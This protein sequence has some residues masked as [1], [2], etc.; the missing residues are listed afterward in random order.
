[1][2]R[3]DSIRSLIAA[4]GAALAPGAAR[5]QAGFPNRPIR[6][7]VP[8]SPGGGVDTFAR[9][10]AAKVKTQRDVHFFV[11]NRTGGNSTIGGLD[12]QHA[13][14]DGST[15]LFHASTH[16]VA[17]L[18]MRNV[19]YDP[20][21]D[22]TPIA[23]AGNA[24]LLHIVAN[25]RQEKTVAEI[26]AAAKANR[27]TWS[28][29]TAQLGAPGHL[30]AV[31]FNQYTG[32][33]LPIIVYRGTAPAANDVVGGHVP[34]MIEAILA[35]LPLVRTGSVRAVGLT[36]RR[37]SPLAP[38]IP[39]MAELGLPALNFGAWWGMWGPPGMPDDLV[40]TINGWVNAAVEE[41]GREGRLAAL[42]IEPAA[43]TPQ[44]F[45]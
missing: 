39:T 2:N 34:M 9:L 14:P 35:L 4:A 21:A 15:V 37:R 27:E 24:P 22:F 33:D 29:A 5:S 7:V 20:A 6:I 41:L 40:Q 12:V 26:V 31:A 13:T 43:E 23:L 36:S 44:A 1:M 17:R 45:A 30:A 8:V 25:S 16:N 3:R 10:I 18:V 42:G 19:P 28:F 11:E 38:E 32:L